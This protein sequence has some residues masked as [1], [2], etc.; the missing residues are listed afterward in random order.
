M[1]KNID[2]II[3]RN[4]LEDAQNLVTYYLTN[5]QQMDRE[6]LAHVKT[7]CKSIKVKEERVTG[8]NFCIIRNGIYTGEYRVDIYIYYQNEEKNTVIFDVE[9][10]N[11][12]PFMKFYETKRE[13][14]K[15]EIRENVPF[16]PSYKVR[17]YELEYGYKSLFNIVQVVE[18]NIPNIIEI[19]EMN[20]KLDSVFYVT[21]NYTGSNQIILY[22]E[23]EDDNGEIL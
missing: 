1:E 21:Y 12:S 20:F 19:I 17:E 13:K 15:R 6:L 4:L 7:L 2:A 22:E 9:E 14:I 8:I 3:K 5:R 18:Q 23:K 16:I 11:I 10:W